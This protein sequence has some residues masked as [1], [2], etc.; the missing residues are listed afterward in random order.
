MLN[1]ENNYYSSVRK[2]CGVYLIFYNPPYSSSDTTS[3][4][5][6]Q[7]GH[8]GLKQTNKRTN[9]KPY[10]PIRPDRHL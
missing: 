8:R 7:P 3:R 10:K 4:E 1:E 9:E 5:K 6:D 2:P